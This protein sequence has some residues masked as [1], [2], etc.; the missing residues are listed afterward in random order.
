MADYRNTATIYCDASYAP[1]EAGYGFV[2]RIGTRMIAVSRNIRA[3]VR[4]SQ[5]AEALA[6][7]GSLQVSHRAMPGMRKVSVHTDCFS[8]ASALQD[9]RVPR[10]LDEVI[11]AI[12]DYAHAN[13]VALDVQ[14]VKGH[15]REGA[16][17]SANALAHRLAW[18]GRHGENVAYSGE[19]SI[20]WLKTMARFDSRLV[21]LDD[22][23]CLPVDAVADYLSVPQTTVAQL[24][25][26]GH[27]DYWGA[28]VPLY[29]VHRVMRKLI[30]MRG[31]RQ[32]M[33]FDE[34]MPAFGI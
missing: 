25:R 14:W 27:L 33:D 34:G 9:R 24:L 18:M 10:G 12:R 8:V 30:E 6:V 17:G 20:D 2:A 23:E 4:S 11:L 22:N 5:M 15:R 29:S 13:V 32:D 31:P 28:G 21:A 16:V 7:M 26:H 3:D 1:G 19:F